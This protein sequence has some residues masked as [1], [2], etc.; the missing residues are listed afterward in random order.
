MA[1]GKK[2]K[3]AEPDVRVQLFPTDFHLEVWFCNEIDQAA[4]NF[5]NRY[6]YDYQYWYDD[7]KKSGFD[8]V[9]DMN[10]QSDEKAVIVMN[11]GSKDVGVLVH[12]CV[13]VFHHIAEIVGFDTSYEGQEFQAYFIEYVFNE[14]M[15]KWPQ[16]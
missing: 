12:E 14:I 3:P 11:L 10:Y 16:K 9:Q 2:I 13:H 15:K 7:L 1:K 6:Q 8:F 4:T 5:A